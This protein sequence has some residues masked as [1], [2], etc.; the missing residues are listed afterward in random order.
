MF[1]CFEVLP[2]CF[3]YTVVYWVDLECNKGI[4]YHFPHCCIVLYCGVLC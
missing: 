2:Y 1:V 3:V 4:Q